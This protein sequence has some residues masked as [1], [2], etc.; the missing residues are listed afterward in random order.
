MTNSTNITIYNNTFSKI[1]VTGPLI[2][3]R[4]NENASQIFVLVIQNTFAN[5]QTYLSATIMH[6]SKREYTNQNYA[7]LLMKYGGGTLIYS[8]YFYNI[9]GC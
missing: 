3:I 9:A 5:I 6:I 7:L 1:S 8:N 2:D 4:G